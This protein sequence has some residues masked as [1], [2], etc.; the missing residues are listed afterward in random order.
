M[1]VSVA[2]GA[3]FAVVGYYA[4]EGRV[5][6][7][8]DPPEPQAVPRL[9][10]SLIQD[11]PTRTEVQ[12]EAEPQDSEADGAVADSGSGC[13]RDAPFTGPGTVAGTS[14]LVDK[15]FA[16]WVPE[17]YDPDTRHVLLML[18]HDD[19]QNGMRFMTLTRFPQIADDLGFVIVAPHDKS[20]M[21]WATADHARVAIDARA[22][23]TRELCID[24]DRVFAVGFGAG[25]RVVE[26]LP[27][28]TE[29]AGIST[30]AY[31]SKKSDVVCK[32]ERP[33][34]YIHLAPLE[35]QYSPVEGGRGCGG[36]HHIISLDAKEKM[37]RE[38]NHCSSQRPK[39]YFEHKGSTC[40]AWSCGDTPFASCHL[41]GGRNWP[42]M[43]GRLV[44]LK[45]CDGA[46]ARFPFA[47]TIWKFFSH[48]AV[49]PD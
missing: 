41:A 14:T 49:A 34:P 10:R 8:T 21:A 25:G 31:R 47:R 33:V 38:R 15:N 1:A 40:M 5:P 44:D 20:M 9:P 45:G 43:A 30:V 46:P 17:R 11:P 48:G 29:L 24:Q 19:L 28:V 4:M 2:V 23:V 32:P 7:A 6:G 36:L 16:V 26:E 42:G 37:W 12:D 35:D 3:A 13:G 39:V 27:C 22:A 18:F